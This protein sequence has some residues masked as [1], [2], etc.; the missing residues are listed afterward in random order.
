MA[1]TTSCHSA[2]K[3]GMLDAVLVVARYTA[4]AYQEVMES[5]DEIMQDAKD[6][7]LPLDVIADVVQYTNGARTILQ[8]TSC[9]RVGHNCFLMLLL[10]LLL[11]LSCVAAAVAVLVVSV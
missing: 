11:L 8:C 4:T 6:A 3:P 5:S 2:F 10:L 9:P 7:A 1:T